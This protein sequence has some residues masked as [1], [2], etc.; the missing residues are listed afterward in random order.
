MK[1]PRIPLLAA[2]LVATICQAAG[3]APAALLGKLKS[4]AGSNG[5]DCGSV[6]LHESPETAISC[7]TSANASGKPYRLAVE[8]QGTDSIA[9][10]G[11]VR[12]ERG[13]LWALYYDSDPS[14][15]SG[16]GTTLSVVLCREI[17][18][19]AQGNDVIECKPVIG[20]P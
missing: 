10:Q 3:A 13:K 4:L 19:A 2:T 6:S 17:L 18:F 1:S 12:D 15:G 16:A 8:F 14:G 5:Q 7:A 20:E 11:A 9:W